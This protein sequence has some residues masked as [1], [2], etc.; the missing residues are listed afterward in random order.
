MKIPLGIEG[1]TFVA[2]GFGQ[3]GYWTSR[4]LAEDGAKLIGVSEIDG[5]IMNREGL[6]V[7]KVKAYI[8][9]NGGVKGYPDAEYTPKDEAIYMAW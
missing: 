5:S 6:D 4:F 8:L 1:K 9:E 2:Q 3:I 7:E